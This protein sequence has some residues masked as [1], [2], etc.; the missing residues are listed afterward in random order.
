MSLDP[1]SPSGWSKVRDTLVASLELRRDALR[2]AAQSIRDG[3]PDLMKLAD[4]KMA[5]A[6]ALVKDARAVQEA[7]RGGS[8]P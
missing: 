4:R 8:K 6:N 5:E 3:N 1:E 7:R 2:L